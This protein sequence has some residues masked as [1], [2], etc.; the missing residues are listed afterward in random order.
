M[1]ECKRKKDAKS[2]EYSLSCLLKVHNTWWGALHCLS[3][4]LGANGAD[5]AVQ[6]TGKT[7]WQSYRC[8][9]EEEPQ[10]GTL[11][12]QHRRLGGCYQMQP[13]HESG[14]EPRSWGQPATKEKSSSAQVDITALR[15][16][17]ANT[18]LLLFERSKCRIILLLTIKYSTWNHVRISCVWFKAFQRVIRVWWPS[19]LLHQT[20]LY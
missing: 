13:S 8:R 5:S 11:L 1:S 2:V 18:C 20:L 10:G 6:T 19:T 12:G 4:C 3:L 9:S 15:L 17:R 14:A 16:Y 7:C